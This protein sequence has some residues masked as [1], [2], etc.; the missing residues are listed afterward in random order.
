MCIEV[1]E[2][3]DNNSSYKLTVAVPLTIT[4]I[5]CQLFSQGNIEHTETF[6]RIVNNNDHERQKKHSFL[7][8]KK[9]TV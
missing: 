3:R 6:K 9:V 4:V 5:I 8:Q 2:S 7:T 1:S